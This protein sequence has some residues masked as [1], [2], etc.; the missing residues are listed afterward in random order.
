MRITKAQLGHAFIQ[1]A[2]AAGKTK[3]WRLVHERYSGWNIEAPT[4]HASSYPF[5]I[6]NKTAQEL[7]TGMQMATTALELQQKDRSATG[8]VNKHRKIVEQLQDEAT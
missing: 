4:Q 2:T 7:L 1:L 3:D 8:I 6:A 5:G